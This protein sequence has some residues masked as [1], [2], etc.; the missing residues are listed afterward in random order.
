MATETELKLRITPENLARLRRHALFRTHQITPPVT[1]HLHNIYYDTPKLD[2]HKGR[3]ALRLRRVGGRWLQ[4]LKGGGQVM[5]GLHQ[6]NE[7]EAPVPSAKLDFSVFEAAVL[8]ENLPHPLRK[9]LKP[10]FVTD[11]HRTSRMLQW[12]GAQIEVCMDHGE[13]KTAERGTPISEVEL[14]LKSGDPQQLFA[15][16]L[17]LLDIVPFEL[18]GISKAEQG[19]RL[20]TGYIASPV[21]AKAPELCAEDSVAAVLQTLIWSCLLHLQQNLHGALH[22]ADPEYLHQMRVAIRRLR[23]VLRITEKLH[24]DPE[25]SAL[26]EALAA[27]GIG[28]GKIRDWDV[29]IAA[30]EVRQAQMH[31]PGFEALLA[32]SVTARDVCYADLRGDKQ[33]RALQRLMLRFAIWM[34]SPYWQQVTLHKV[35][36]YAIRHLHRLMK[37]YRLASQHLDELDAAGLHALRIQAKKLRYSAEFFA[38]LF[39]MQKAKSFMAALS[40]VQEVLGNMND[41][42]VAQRL[43]DEMAV[44]L[45]DHQEAIGMVKGW[46]AHEQSQHRCTLIKAVRHFA[47][48]SAFWER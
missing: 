28:L 30:Q 34:N 18:E 41:G 1:H 3:M 6:R 44:Q 22:T 43:L 46:V 2:L 20:L 21:K 45:F 7:W 36:D 37:R 39:E 9:H 13:V 32:H 8:D 40:E 31:L 11:F 27:C 12:Q 10:V 19:F 38:S 14:E 42:E 4:T 35:T 24:A 16:A 15:L 5:G 25:L 26:R 47:A 17:T 29:F 33:Q 23:V 48:Q